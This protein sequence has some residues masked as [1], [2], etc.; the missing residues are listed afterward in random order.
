MNSTHQP[1]NGGLGRAIRSECKRQRV[2]IGNTPGIGGDEDKLGR[3]GI[4][5]GLQEGKDGLEEQHGA[6]RVDLPVLA[7]LAGRR[8]G[9]RAGRGGDAGVGNHD[10]QVGDAMLGPELLDR[11][12]RVC[13]GLRVDLDD[14]E[15]RPVGFGQG[16]QSLRGWAGWV[17]RAGDDDA[18][19]AE[20][21]FG[22]ESM[23]DTAGCARD[24]I[25]GHVALQLEGLEKTQEMMK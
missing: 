18:V 19:G 24:E 12:K 9:Y 8:G 15:L 11:F 5:N 6:Q 16:E 7:Q 20:E 14:D 22:Y 25:G 13:L 10:V 21:E 17:S 23:P 2:D 1:I 4:R 3:R